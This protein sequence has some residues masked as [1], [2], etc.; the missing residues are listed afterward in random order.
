M[1][2][3]ECPYC[4]HVNPPGSKFCNA[5]GAPLHLLPCS[6]CG[7]V[8]DAAAKACRECGAALAP[9]EPSRAASGSATAPAEVARH[10]GP[11]ADA[12]LFASVQDLRD[13]LARIEA[14][15]AGHR[16]GD[17]EPDADRESGFDARKVAPSRPR[18]SGLAG[19]VWPIVAGVALLSGAIGGYLILDRRLTVQ[20]RG[21][22]TPAEAVMEAPAGV[23]AIPS[24]GAPAANAETA[25]TPPL[26]GPLSAATPDGAQAAAAGPS[27]ESPLPAEQ[28][29]TPSQRT[30]EPRPQSAPTAAD[31]PPQEESSPRTA[32]PP[33]ARLGPC[34]EA[35]AALGLCTLDPAQGKH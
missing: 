3:R 13:R 29:S 32:T 1:L 28:G 17:K 8:N 6:H 18:R 15:Q 14:G 30:A 22:P 11:D 33:P 12:E 16:P 2:R 34:T 25:P 26:A 27:T 7:A 20:D 21:A 23:A 10:D 9:A 35:V 5:C 31:E 24:T 4:E 19:A